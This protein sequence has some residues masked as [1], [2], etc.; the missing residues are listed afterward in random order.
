MSMSH[1]A[2]AKAVKKLGLD[3]AAQHYAG[4]GLPVVDVA[5]EGKAQDIAIMVSST[6]STLTASSWFKDHQQT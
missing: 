2:V 5:V 3:S 4:Y 6:P 1:M